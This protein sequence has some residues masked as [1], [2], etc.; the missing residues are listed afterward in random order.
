VH[1]GEEGAMQFLARMF[2]TQMLCYYHYSLDK[3]NH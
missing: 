1:E 3:N 2:V